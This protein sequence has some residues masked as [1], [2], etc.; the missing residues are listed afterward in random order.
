MQRS[1]A[2]VIPDEPETVAFFCCAEKE[3]R[4]KRLSSVIVA[5]F[6][7]VLV[8]LMLFLTACAPA[9]QGFVELPE[10]VS[11]G[12]VAVVLVG[13]SFVFAKLI[14]MVPFLKFLEN[15]REPLGLAIAW[16]LIGFIQN[17]VPDAY[18]AVA[19]IALQLILAVLALFT[20]AQKLREM[21]VRGFR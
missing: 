20:A 1:G 12:I 10:R 7:V 5:R 8:F 21:R 14:A 16:Q 11:T 18:G 9:A 15:F 19:I 4:M 13:V 3:I 17:I 2:T 6:V